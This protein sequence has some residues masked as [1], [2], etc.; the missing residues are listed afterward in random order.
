MKRGSEAKNESDAAVA[1][2]AEEKRALLGVAR[3]V[4]V[5]HLSGKRFTAP[6]PDSPAL[7]E[8]RATFVTLRVRDTNELRGCRGECHASQRLVESVAQM[9]IAAA[10]DPRFTPVAAEELP[11]LHIEISVLSPLE[12]IEPDDVVVGRHG[13][14][15]V[16]G[17]FS[18][19]L[20]PQVAVAQGWDREAF[21]DGVCRKAGLPGEAWKADGVVLFGFE[22]DAWGEE[23]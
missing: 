14:M 12:P 18:G 16:C 11:T 10:T 21:L 9:A 8:P 22:A 7:L 19:L 2:S 23:G 17:D 3:Q 6:R 13:L 4:L 1:L 15:I 20:L 5:D